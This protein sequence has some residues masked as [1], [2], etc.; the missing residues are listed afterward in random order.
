MSLIIGKNMRKFGEV[1][2]LVQLNS[3]TNKQVKMELS[4]FQLP[5][6]VSTGP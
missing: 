5:G 6:L 3:L 1:G 2:Q 4:L